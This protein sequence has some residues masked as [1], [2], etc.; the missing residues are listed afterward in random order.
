MKTFSL[1]LQSFLIP[2]FLVHFPS[3]IG[4]LYGDTATR[5][6][7]HRYLSSSPP[8]FL[9]FYSLM[10]VFRC[11]N[12][13]NLAGSFQTHSTA[14]SYHH[15]LLA[16]PAIITVPK[17]PKQAPPPTA[18]IFLSRGRSPLPPLYLF[19]RPPPAFPGLKKFRKDCFAGGEL[20]LGKFTFF[21]FPSQ[22]RVRFSPWA[23]VLPRAFPGRSPITKLSVARPLG[24]R[25]FLCLPGAQP[26]PPSPSRQQF[27]LGFY[28]PPP[29]S[30]FPYFLP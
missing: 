14:P 3:S 20:S 30:F 25:R 11:P 17:S 24:V 10:R 27:T 28:R 23:P 16:V 15:Y 12:R 13:P 6:R 2:V 9:P 21:L 5:P 7:W 18:I 19:D 4:F 1:P 29:S 22:R 8:R 26:P